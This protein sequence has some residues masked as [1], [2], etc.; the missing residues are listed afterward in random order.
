[1][2]EGGQ[3]YSPPKCELMSCIQ[4]KPADEEKHKWIH[5][6][7]IEPAYERASLSTSKIGLW[8]FLRVQAVGTFDWDTREFG[9]QWRCVFTRFVSLTCDNSIHHNSIQRPPKGCIAVLIINGMGLALCRVTSRWS[10]GQ[11]KL[12]RK[13]KVNPKAVPNVS[14]GSCCHSA[15]WHCHCMLLKLVDVTQSSVGWRLHKHGLCSLQWRRKEL[16]AVQLH[17]HW[18]M[19]LFMPEVEGYG[20]SHPLTVLI[21]GKAVCCQHCKEPATACMISMSC[22]APQNAAVA[23]AQQSLSC[24]SMSLPLIL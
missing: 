13:E 17:P 24:I 15:C 19:D 20:T 11:G 1:M 21:L 14:P 3:E 7:A 6:L 5:K 8:G 9:V 16:S 18:R 2:S 22:R 10:R 12:G 4:V 23:A